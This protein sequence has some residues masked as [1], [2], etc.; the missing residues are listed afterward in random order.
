MATVKKKKPAQ[1]RRGRPALGSF[2][3]LLSCG[4]TNRGHDNWRIVEGEGMLVHIRPEH[5][6]NAIRGVE[7]ECV[8]AL[9]FAEFFGPKY[10]ISVGVTVTKIISQKDK[11]ELRIKTPQ[12]IGRVIDVWDHKEG[13]KL[14]PGVYR[15]GKY[16][17]PAKSKKRRAAARGRSRGVTTVVVTN[18]TKQ[19]KIVRTTIRNIVRNARVNTSLLKK[20]AG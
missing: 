15:F 16:T 2:C 3:P 18:R 20:R 4:K 19:K 12:K 14:P 1:K 13:W 8:V 10:D 11:V 7:E 6:A 5:I 9:A 17:L